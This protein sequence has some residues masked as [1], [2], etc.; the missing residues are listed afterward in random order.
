M[1]DSSNVHVGDFALAIGN[2]FGLGRTVTM[3]IISATGRGGFRIESYEDFIQTDAAINPGNSGGALINVRGEPVGI[4]TA[5]ITGGG[6]GSEGI[7]SAI[8]VTIA[9][10]VMDQI[11]RH[12]KVVRGRLGVT[13]QAVTPEIA[14][15]FGLA[16][17]HG[18]LVGDVAP[19]G[20][21]AQA[22][23][24]SGDIV[25]EMNRQ[26]T[27]DSSELQVKVSLTAPRTT[28]RRDGH[29]REVAV[30]LGEMPSTSE[31]AR[32]EGEERGPKL[33][34][35][36]EDLTPQIACQLGLQTGTFGAVITEIEPEVRRR[37]PG[38]S[39]VT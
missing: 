19:G 2:P 33:G 14:Q 36:L 10:N 21:A 30:K 25:L 24:K 5:I 11:I 20:P 4:N 27:N 29:E 31:R 1:G 39:A 22:G 26:R 3:G 38:C 18:A 34:V 32:S 6:G 23:I 37:K 17:P 35:D 13:I 7:G 28:V 9:R 15:A 12:G 16:E 8:P